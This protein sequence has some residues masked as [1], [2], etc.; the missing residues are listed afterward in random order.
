[1]AQPRQSQ[2]I[3]TIVIRLWGWKGREGIG[4]GVNRMGRGGRR[5]VGWK[6]RVGMEGVGGVEGAECGSGGGWSGGE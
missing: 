1:M 6:G 2:L 5:A 3:G 4:R